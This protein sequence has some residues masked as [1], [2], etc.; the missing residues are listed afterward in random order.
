M[1]SEITE[2]DLKKP[3]WL[4]GRTNHGYPDKGPTSIHEAGPI[5]EGFVG[6]A[7]LHDESW[8]LRQ[9]VKWQEDIDTVMA[10]FQTDVANHFKVH[11]EG[12]ASIALCDC[13]SKPIL[14]KKPAPPF[15]RG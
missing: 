12:L 5:S 11:D 4:Q 3:S 8:W 2:L 9:Q 1:A 15:E 6:A 10:Q 13:P 7:L 14:P